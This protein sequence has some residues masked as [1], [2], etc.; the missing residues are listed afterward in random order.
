MDLR[1]EERS[2]LG[3]APTRSRPYLQTYLFV[4]AHEPAKA[5]RAL[6]SDVGAVIFDLEASVP[7][8]LK[9][10]ARSC[11][12]GY[13][14]TLVTAS[15]PEVWVRVNVPGPHL[16]ADFQA[17]PFGQITGVIVAQA[18]EVETLVA[19]QEAGVRR[20]IPLIESVLAFS[21]LDQLA[22]VRAVE[23]FAVGTWDLLLDLGLLGLADPD[24]SELIWRLRGDLVIASCRLRLEAPIDG[25]YARLDD[26]SGFRAAC[27]RAYHL[28]FGGKL[29]IHPQQIMT[30]T[31][32]FGPDESALRLAREIV[33]AYD[34]AVQA[35]RG[36]IQVHGRMVDGP[37]VARARLLLAR[38]QACAS[39]DPA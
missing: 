1:T 27:E 20:L 2:G 3:G 28:G 15:S 22:S 7:D 5:A 39:L 4:P 36:A 35:G 29:L 8:S 31:S 34:S 17:L 9:V 21:V 24:D 26:I 30:A 11:V 10:E 14:R 33:E 32:V 38:W 18:E 37:V 25:V 23:R 19:L 6:K 12:R 16:A 13:L